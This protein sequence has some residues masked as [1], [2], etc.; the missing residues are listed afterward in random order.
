[1]RCGVFGGE[2]RNPR[3]A[4]FGPRREDVTEPAPGEA[5]P[6]ARRGVRALRWEG[7]ADG[8]TG[9]IMP[10]L[11]GEAEAIGEAPDRGVRAK[12]G[13]AEALDGGLGEATR[14]APGEATGV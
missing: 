2:P 9:V 3:C 4:A 10:P 7:A 1:M 12:S 5:T 11:G 13:E 14:L 6:A 8:G